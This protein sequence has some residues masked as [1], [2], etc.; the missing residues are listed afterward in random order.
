MNRRQALR[1]STLAFTGGLAG[2][3]ALQ[4]G[5][6]SGAR[7][8]VRWTQELA[9]PQNVVVGPQLVHVDTEERIQG[10]DRTDGAVNWTRQ[11]P[12]RAAIALAPRTLLLHD[13]RQERG[14]DL[15]ALDLETHELRWGVD[16]IAVWPPTVVTDEIAFVTTIG[17]HS[18]DSSQTN[19]E[20][21]LQSRDL[22]R[23]T[24]RWTFSTPGAELPVAL[25]D[26]TL[27]V[28]TMRA[29][30]EGTPA[31]PQGVYALDASNATINWYFDPETPWGPAVLGSDALFVGTDSV[32]NTT[33]LVYALDATDG[34]ERWV[35]EGPTEDGWGLSWPTHVAAQT[36][37]C[38]TGHSRVEALDVE[39]GDPQWRVRARPISPA[40][41]SDG[42]RNNL[43]FVHRDMATVAAID[44]EDGS[45]AWSY[46]AADPDSAND[47]VHIEQHDDRVIVVSDTTAVALDADT[48][49]ERW[50]FATDESIRAVAVNGREFY[51]AT[52]EQLYA[53][54]PP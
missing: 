29:T 44:L 26:G 54:V 1:L 39:T 31:N 49:E 12:T 47:A 40:G 33:P 25:S 13:D 17:G 3:Q 46:T 23:G 15:S 18:A 36:V 48:G 20:E 45:E 8:T 11:V 41:G 35:F 14:P 2:C 27:Y 19:S 51:L 7:P 22:E 43:F 37:L 42:I 38:L 50:S 9:H 53:L 32:E 5:A 28:T 6:S 34:T 10:F 4:F 30:V 21:G 16:H 24:V 52:E